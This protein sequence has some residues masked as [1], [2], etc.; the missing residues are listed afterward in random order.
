MM[1]GFL[2]TDEYPFLGMHLL[3]QLFESDWLLYCELG[4][5]LAIKFDALHFLRRDKSTIGESE[6]AECIPEADNPET[7]KRTL[8]VVTIPAGIFPRPDEGFLRGDE[9]RLS[10]P[11]ET[12][13]LRKYILPAFVGSDASFDSGHKRFS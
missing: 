5:H 7:S 2:F 11:A 4:E 6:E 3:D 10:S 13:G 12:D 9:V 8:F 1:G